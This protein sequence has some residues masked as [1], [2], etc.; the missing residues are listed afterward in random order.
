MAYLN[1]NKEKLVNL[2]YSLT[3]EILAT[4]RAGG[5]LSTTI[6]CCNTRKYHGL[7]V[8]PIDQFDGGKHVLLSS[9]DETIIQHGQSFN[10]G[11]HKYEGGVYEPK[12]HK[13]CREVSYE[14]IYAITYRVGGVVLKKEI[15]LSHDE[16]Q[17]LIRYTLLEAQSQTTLCLK[18]FLAFRNINALSQANMDINTK[19]EVVDNGI[20]SNLYKGFPDLHMQLSKK[21]EFVATPD[22]YNKIEYTEEQDR[23][24]A[25][26]EDLYVPGYFEVEIKKGE[27]I[28]FSASLEPT[29]VNR[30]KQKFEKLKE[31]RAPRNNFINCLQ[32]SAS[33]F[34]VK[35]GKDTQVVAGYPWFGVW[36]RDTF[37]SLP[38]LTLSNGDTKTCKAVLDTMCKYLKDGLFPNICGTKVSNSSYNVV[39]TS[40]WFFKTL[41]EYGKAVGDDVV[42]K[43]YKKYMKEILEAYKEGISHFSYV[44]ASNGLIWSK[45]EGKAL[46]WM[47]AVYDG[48]PVTPRSGYAVEVNALWYN[49]ICYT[50]RLAK[51]SKDAAFVKQWKDMPELIEKSFVDTFWNEQEGYLADYVDEYGQNIDIRPNQLFACSLEYSPITDDMKNSVLDVATRML[52]TMKGIRTLSPRDAEY[53]GLYVGDQ[54]SRDE[55]YHQ[56]TVWPWLLGAYVEACFRLHGKAF[57]R[58]ANYILENFEENMT[59]Y[60]VCSIPEVFDGNPPHFPAGTISQAWSVGELLRVNRMVEKYMK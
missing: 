38:G 39:D 58:K 18:P 52:L 11:I 9:L 24:Y 41:Q 20:T 12:G 42:W 46:T 25:F 48:V 30:L 4:N 7:L 27:P 44:N 59:T 14:P 40:L 10:L 36:A 34:I 55:A 1:F 3:R 28:V 32:Y 33:Q 6:V 43:Q 29:A 2:E 15:I 49:A 50:L 31:A 54:K 23:G 17:L 8:V 35:K 16:P 53:K 26:Q 47:D 45:Q 13:Y 37:I 5:Y 21:N 56:G 19:Y 51:E 57:A 60:G 22:W